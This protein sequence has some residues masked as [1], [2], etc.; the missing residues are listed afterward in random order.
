MCSW[1]QVNCVVLCEV[2]FVTKWD[3]HVQL[4][5]GELC[6]VLLGGFCNEMALSCA[7]TDR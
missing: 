7:G 1:W 2:D 5:A 6:C 3:C 4:L